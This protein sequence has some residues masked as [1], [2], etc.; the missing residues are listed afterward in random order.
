MIVTGKA[1]REM[2]AASAAAEYAATGGKVLTLNY[3]PG[4]MDT[5]MVREVVAAPALDP[6]LHGFFSGVLETVRVARA[7]TGVLHSPPLA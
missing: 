4:T 1:A 6:Y 5:D 3:D 2:F 7:V